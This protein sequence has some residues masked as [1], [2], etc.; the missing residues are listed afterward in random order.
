MVQPSYNFPVGTS[1]KDETFKKIDQI[2]PGYRGYNTIEDIKA[3][4]EQI[5]AQLLKE[6]NKLVEDIEPLR[7][8]LER[9]MHLSII[10][11]FNSM[12][13]NLKSTIKKIETGK[14]DYTSKCQVYIPEKEA[15]EE[16]YRIDYTLLND[17]ENVFNLSQ[18]LYRISQ[19]DM[20]LTNIHKMDMSLANI[21]ENY[22]RRSRAIFCMVEKEPSSGLVQ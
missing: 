9:N 3:V 7:A 19:E 15:L 13:N 16:I 14:S 21:S 11:D 12:L 18:E 22:D 1:Y 20:I 2:I 17:A 8:H 10:P 6:L 4:D 5:K